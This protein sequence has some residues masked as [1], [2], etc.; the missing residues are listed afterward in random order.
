MKARIYSYTKKA[1]WH[2]AISQNLCFGHFI[3]QKLKNKQ[4]VCL[5]FWDISRDSRAK[6]YPS[7]EK[8]WG[9]VFTIIKTV[10]KRD[11]CFS[12][13]YDKLTMHD[14]DSI[15]SPIIGEYCVSTPSS[16]IS[17][18]NHLFIHFYSDSAYTGPGFKLEYTA[19]SKA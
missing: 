13:H 19:T 16:Q 3:I 8:M 14:G 9:Y 18:S 12:D 15:T 10:M 2:L 1:I 11:Y 6:I 4:L 17:S 5:S 7:I